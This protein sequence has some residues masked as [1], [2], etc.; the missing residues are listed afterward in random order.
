MLS[1]VVFIFFASLTCIKISESHIFGFDFIGFHF[2]CNVVWE[3]DR[4][5]CFVFFTSLTCMKITKLHILGFDFIDFCFHFAVVLE[6]SRFVFY[7]VC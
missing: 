6:C 4:L 5:V 2:L 1:Q 7:S 3:C